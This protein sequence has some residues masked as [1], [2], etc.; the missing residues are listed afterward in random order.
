MAEIKIDERAARLEIKYRYALSFSTRKCLHLYRLL[1]DIFIIVT[2]L[3]HCSTRQLLRVFIRDEEAF[4]C[5]MQRTTAAGRDS[6][7]NA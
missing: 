4:V 7:E 3:K 2:L 1:R 5:N 6:R